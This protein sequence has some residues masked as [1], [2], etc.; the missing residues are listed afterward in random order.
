MLFVFTGKYIIIIII[1]IWSENISK[2]NIITFVLQ[3]INQMCKINVKTKCKCRLESDI[4]MYE[5]SFKYW[6]KIFLE[7]N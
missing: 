6:L 2:Y 7:W 1:I 3:L 5:G 4:Q